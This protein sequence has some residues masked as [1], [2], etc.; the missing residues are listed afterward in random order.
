MRQRLLALS[1]LVV[2]GAGCFESR[3][4]KNDVEPTGFAR[5]IND[6]DLRQMSA[7]EQYRIYNKLLAT[8]YKGESADN[9]FDLS[10]GLA[11]P[12]RK[13]TQPLIENLKEKL[14]KSVV[15]DNYYAQLVNAKHGV[16]IVMTNPN[17]RA[18]A[19]AM[20][21]EMPLTRTHYMHWIAYQLTNAILFSP[22]LELDSVSQEDAQIIYQ[23][24]V[25]MLQEHRS[26]SEILYAHLISRENWR[27]FRSPEDNTRE[28]MEIYLLRF[29]DSE[30]PKAATACKNWYLDVN[31]AY[32]LKFN[33]TPTPNVTPQ[34]GLLDRDDIVSCEDFYRAITKHP[35]LAAAITSRLIDHFFYGYS[36][37]FK[38]AFIN[39]V[40]STDPKYFDDIF[41]SIVFS[42]EYLTKVSRA[43]SF[44]ETFLGTGER[45]YWYAWGGFFRV[46]TGDDAS[47]VTPNLTNINQQAMT[48]KLGRPWHIPFDSLS[49]A[50]Y[51]KSVRD[52]LFLDSRNDQ[53]GA[54]DGGW[55]TT[56]INQ[57][58]I[59][60][61]SDDDF[62]DY[63][64][65]SSLTRKPTD[66]E[67]TTL[68]AIFIAQNVTSRTNKAFI[69]FDYASRLAESYHF[70]AL[71]EMTSYGY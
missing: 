11:M 33:G 25:A 43:K 37:M 7:L 9:F 59:Q 46:K 10:A 19:M 5:P 34:T 70:P 44:E 24:L 47:S 65:I 13:D 22:G 20:L 27:R 15:D 52:E 42:Y 6:G 40:V 68:Q 16:S 18:Y 67:R 3:Q 69:T 49:L 66:L 2:L 60:S 57:P 62:I 17:P 63:L 12:K 58:N 31:D 45:L 64:F 26:I 29:D 54:G 23:R 36:V 4:P 50:F 1:I 51:H 21:Q 32:T 41:E 53:N 28:M 56:L 48:Y 61:L 8:L 30:V 71:K 14:H 38:Q 35:N 39:S 55:R